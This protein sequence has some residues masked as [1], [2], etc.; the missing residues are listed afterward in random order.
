M[1]SY[2]VMTHELTHMSTWR[3]SMVSLILRLRPSF[4]KI[5][6]RVEKEMHS[7]PNHVKIIRYWYL[8][9]SRL[10]S[11]LRLLQTS[12]EELKTQCQHY[13]SKAATKN[14]TPCE[15]S[16]QSMVHLPEY[17]GLRG[18]WCTSLRVLVVKGDK[19][20]NVTGYVLKP[21]W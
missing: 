9:N 20:V 17:C 2:Y 3:H 13:Q 11:Q 6:L 10:S 8:D 1:N 15:A 7:R 14:G 19:L 21:S 16:R 18:C 5:R 4:L 12:E